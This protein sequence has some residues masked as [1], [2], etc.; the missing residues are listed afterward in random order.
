MNALQWT[1][2]RCSVNHNNILIDV[3]RRLIREWCNRLQN[4][5]STNSQRQYSENAGATK[6]RHRGVREWRLT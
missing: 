1:T 6:V 2:G 3:Q 4:S 5:I